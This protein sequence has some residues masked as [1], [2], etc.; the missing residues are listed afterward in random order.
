[1]SEQEQIIDLQIKISHQEQLLEDLNQAL[2]FQQ[3]QIDK[4]EK[5]L[6]SLTDSQKANSSIKS[7]SEEVPPPHY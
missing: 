5:Q 6:R 2:I 4:L 1:M 7:Q 3:K